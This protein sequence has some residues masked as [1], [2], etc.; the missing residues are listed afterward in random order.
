MTGGGILTTTALVK[1]WGRCNLPQVFASPMN[2][3]VGEIWFE[4]PQPLSNILAKYLFT[5]ER[6]SVQVHPTAKN[7]PTGM[8]KDE[9]WLVTEV[10][11]GARLAVGFKVPVDAA[12]VHRGALDGS[13]MQM[14]EWIEVKVND[15]IYVPAGTVHSMGAGLTLI[16]IQQDTDITHRLYDYGRGRPLN[17]DDAMASI[18]S[19]PHPPEFR[20]RID[21]TSEQILVEGPHFLLAQSAG[22]PSRD[23]QA[24]LQGAVQVLPIDG[25]CLIDGAQIE[26]GA[27]GWADCL[28]CID[29]SHSHRSLLIANPLPLLQNPSASE[30]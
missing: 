19:D 15:F 24:R 27:A 9:C 3:P 22:K 13:I 28:E 23:L 10:E 12:A 26:P 25:C 6:L 18:R 14:L 7:S 17:L 4:R 11:P 16:E 20:R 21:P 1:P 2:E 30:C 8:G 5:E 29:F